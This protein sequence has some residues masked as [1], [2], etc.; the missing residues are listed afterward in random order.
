MSGERVRLFVA[1]E[2]PD[3]ARDALTSWRERSVGH[4]RGLRLVATASLHLTLCFLGSRSPTDV[5]QIAAACETLSGPRFALSFG[6]VVWLPPR[7]PGVLAVEIDDPDGELAQLQ[8][9]L[10]DTLQTAGWYTPEPRP[11]RAHVTIGRVRRGA[12][13]Q[14]KDVV[15]PARCRFDASVVT[16]YRSRPVAGGSQYDPLTRVALG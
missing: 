5:A 10:S 15:A 9:S 11:F 7:R 1:L 3:E 4:I 16:L 8:R 14:A 2:L 13:I 12:Q 6:N